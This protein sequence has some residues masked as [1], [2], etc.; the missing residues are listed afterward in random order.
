MSTSGCRDGSTPEQ[1]D[2]LLRL[3]AAIGEDAYENDDGFFRRL[4]SAFR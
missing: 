1:R 3:G 4:R 2:E